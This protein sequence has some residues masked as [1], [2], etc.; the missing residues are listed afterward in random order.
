[1]WLYLVL[2][3]N[4]EKILPNIN[5]KSIKSNNT[6]TQFKIDIQGIKPVL[7]LQKWYSLKPYN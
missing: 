3:I 4:N 2:F 5:N 6:K 1:M 7:I